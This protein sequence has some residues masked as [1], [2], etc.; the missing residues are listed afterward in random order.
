MN[1]NFLK[2]IGSFWLQF[3]KDRKVLETFGTAA[4]EMLSSAYMDLAGLVLSISHDNVPVYDRLKWDTLAIRFGDGTVVGGKH[5]FPLPATLN[6]RGLRLAPVLVSS[7]IAPQQ[8]LVQNHDFVIGDNYIEFSRDPFVSPDLPIR[9]VAGDLQIQFWV[10]TAEVDTNRIWQRYGHFIGKWNYS[11]QAYKNFVRGMF[12]TRM[13]GPIVNRIETGLQLV[14]G[15]PVADGYG[16]EIVLSVTRHDDRWIV[17]TNLQ[18]HIIMPGVNVRVGPG[19]ILKPFQAITDT[20]QVVDYLT[21]PGWW[22]GNISQLPANLGSTV[23]VDKAFEQYL[24]YNTFLVKIN[25]T[26][27]LRDISGLSRTSIFDTKSLVEFLMEFKPSYTYVFPLFA[28]HLKEIIPPSVSVSAYRSVWGMEDRHFGYPLYNT[29]FS[30]LYLQDRKMLWPIGEDVGVS[31]VHRRI[32]THLNPREP[33]RQVF[34]IPYSFEEVINMGMGRKLS[35]EL[36]LCDLDVH[37]RWCSPVERNPFTLSDFAGLPDEFTL[38]SQKYLFRNYDLSMSK[39]A[40]DGLDLQ[41]VA[42]QGIVEETSVSEQVVIPE[43]AG[44]DIWTN[45]YRDVE[46][47]EDLQ[48]GPYT[49]SSGRKLLDNVWLGIARSREIYKTDQAVIGCENLQEDF[50]DVVKGHLDLSSQC[51]LSWLISLRNHQRLPRQ[52]NLSD[53]KYFCSGLDLNDI[54]PFSMK[55][56]V[57]SVA[58]GQSSLRE[59]VALVDDVISEAH[60]RERSYARFARYVLAD[61]QDLFGGICLSPESEEVYGSE[62]VAKVLERLDQE[63]ENIFKRPLVLGDAYNLSDEV[64]PGY[65]IRGMPSVNLKSGGDL[66]D[67]YNLASVVPLRLF[68]R[69]HVCESTD[70]LFVDDVIPSGIYRYNNLS[71]GNDLAGGFDLSDGA[72]RVFTL[73][74]VPY[75]NSLELYR[76]GEMLNAGID[77]TLSGNQ[78]T[79]ARGIATANILAFYRRSGDGSTIFVDHET[80]IGPVNGINTEFV[81][82]SDVIEQGSLRVYV[83]GILYL[84]DTY[85][86]VTPYLRFFSPPSDGSVVRVFYRKYSRMHFVDNMPLLERSVSLSSG[87]IQLDFVQP[88]FVQSEIDYDYYL[89]CASDNGHVKIFVDGRLQTPEFDYILDDMMVTMSFLQEKQPRV[90]Y[91]CAC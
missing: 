57:E 68:E 42:R 18:D 5:R 58:E 26:P 76:G 62:G 59:D 67:G 28:L 53:K 63:M 56:A 11:S 77:Y 79:F 25:I 65:F 51:D 88:D 43:D 61:G 39:V 73:P 10:P 35:D 91:R 2:G 21:E 89:P 1:D 60:F 46:H 87:F 30:G 3:F 33:Y 90:Y 19:D 45:V 85:R 49:L 83:D 34:F 29:L 52:Y 75:G 69:V 38:K 71:D 50:G 15:L 31:Q 32:L 81:L 74:D 37:R 66:N 24:K 78:I 40:E 82:T 64:L 9:D 14:A 55:M 13:F 41:R 7:L 23:D 80:P 44:A 4:T 72:Y 17:K 22:K 16:N 36:A 12:H 6:N 48:F 8:I 47:G 20:V 54:V 86:L 27:Y 70:G 84:S